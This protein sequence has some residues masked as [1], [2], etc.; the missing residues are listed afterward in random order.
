MSERMSEDMSER[1]SENMP[2]GALSKEL[3]AVPMSHG[4]RCVKAIAIRWT[5]DWSRK[6]DCLEQ[7]SSQEQ[8]NATSQWWSS[9]SGVKHQC[10]WCNKPQKRHVKIWWAMGV[11][12]YHQTC[13]SWLASELQVYTANKMHKDLLHHFEKKC[14][15]PPLY[16]TQV[17]LK[18][19]HTPQ[20]FL[21]PHEL[22]SHM[23]EHYPEAFKKFWMPGGESQISPFWSKFQHTPAMAGRPLFST[24]N[25]RSRAIPISI[26]GNA[27]PTAGKGKA[28]TKMPLALSWVSCLTAGSTREVCNMLYAVSWL[29]I[30]H[31]HFLHWAATVHRCVIAIAIK[32]S[33]AEVF[34]VCR[35]IQTCHLRSM[36]LCWKRAK[37]VLW[38]WPS[39]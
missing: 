10:N 39:P 23:W 13:N 34:L 37:V 38:M 30:Q 9:G 4:D 3:E 33:P 21:M 32:I 17:P 8:K 2:E 35:R 14:P 12:R 7:G 20:S 15:L 24:E 31:V 19:R 11:T 5:D 6:R 29:F 27:V 36:K 22:F 26:H 18:N 1:M 16:T 28:W 25:W